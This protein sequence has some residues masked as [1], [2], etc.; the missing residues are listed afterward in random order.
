MT[1]QH[2]QRGGH[3]EGIQYAGSKVPEVTVW[4][5]IA[6]ILTT[7]MGEAVSDW[8]VQ[9]INPYVA[10]GIGFVAFAVAIIM[11]FSVRKYTTWVY[12][13]TVAMVAVFGTMVADSLHVAVGIPYIVTAPA[14]FA[15]VL[16]IFAIWYR[17][18]GTLS[19]HSIT[20]SRR[21]LF[22]W[23]TVCATFAL[24]TAT[25]DLTAATFHLGY[26][27]SGFMFL[28][29]IVIP[30]LAYRLGFNAVASF[31]IGYIL[32]RPI[33][34]SFADYFGFPKHSG[35]VGVGHGGVSLVSGILVALCIAYLAVTRTGDPAAREADPQYSRSH[36]Y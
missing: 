18:E 12:W 21:E 5:W 26:L 36:A 16:V 4:F 10:V 32:T 23:T 2:R 24:G 31:W 8:S 17:V 22:Y 9:A 27:T 34:A 14:F 35:G 30:L 6:K 25:G 7:A 3:S 13:T 28:A 29:L 33:G 1:G 19:I 15:A 20:T 11:Q